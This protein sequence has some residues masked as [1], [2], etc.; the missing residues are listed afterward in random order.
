MRETHQQ[1]TVVEE[2]P[3]TAERTSPVGQLVY[4]LLGVLEALLAMRIIL[5]LLGA[6]RANA[7]AQ[8]V[9]S[10][11]YPFVAPFFG[12]FG[13][14]FQYGVARLEVETI[15]AMLVYA[16]VGWAIMSFIRVGRRTQ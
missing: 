15:V 7:F 5:S 8:F 3:T 12:L 6:N 2:V 9:Y 13:Y 16:F 11:S 1:T 14:E 4:I 10:V